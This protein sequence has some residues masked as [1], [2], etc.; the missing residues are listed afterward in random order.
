MASVKFVTTSSATEQGS[1]LLIACSAGQHIYV[2]DLERRLRQSI[3]IGS[4]P[5]V[6]T[7]ASLSGSASASASPV[8][9]SPTLASSLSGDDEEES[10]G[11]SDGEGEGEGEGGEED[12]EELLAALHADGGADA[13]EMGESEEDVQSLEISGIVASADGSKI[14]VSFESNLDV[15]VRAQRS[16]AQRAYVHADWTWRRACVRAWCDA[17]GLHR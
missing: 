17:G 1:S 14:Y 4:L 5:C 3:D 10:E 16:R 7:R 6:A 2:Y 13:R 8:D 9:S 15:S 11:V 12:G